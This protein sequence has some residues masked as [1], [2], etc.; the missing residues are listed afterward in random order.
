VDIAISL[1]GSACPTS[2]ESFS[3]MLFP[4]VPSDAAIKDRLMSGLLSGH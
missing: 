2:G 3:L 4:R 1:L